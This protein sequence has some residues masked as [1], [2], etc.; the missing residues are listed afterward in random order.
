MLP[1]FTVLVDGQ[2][3]PLGDIRLLGDGGLDGRILIRADDN[4]PPIGAGG[5][6]VALAQTSFRSLT[7]VD[8]RF[9]M[10]GLPEG[11]F[12]IV[13]LFAGY[14]PVVIP[15]ISIAPNTQTTLRPIELRPDPGQPVTVSGSAFRQDRADHEGI[16]VEWVAQATAESAV[17]TTTNVEGGFTVELAAGIYTVRYRADGYGAVDVPGVAVLPLGAVG[18]VNGYLLPVDAEDRDGDGVIDAQDPDRDGDGCFDSEDKFPDDPNQCLDED[19]DGLS[20]ALDPDDDNDTLS[21]AEEIGTGVD[22]FITDPNN[23]DTDDDGFRDAEDNCPTVPNDGQEDE[24]GDG[25]GDACSDGPRITGFAPTTGAPGTTVFVRGTSFALPVRVSFGGGLATPSVVAPTEFSVTVPE[26]ARTGRITVFSAIGSST[27][28]STFVVLPGPEIIRFSPVAVRPSELVVVFGRQFGESPVVTV[29]GR[30]T[31]PESCPDGIV[32]EAERDGLD[33]ACFRPA[34]GTPSGPIGVNGALSAAALTIL[35]GPRIVRVS[36]NPVAPGQPLTFIGTGLT[37]GQGQAEPVVRFFGSTV[38]VAPTSRSDTM[39]TVTVPMDAQTGDVTIVHP[40]GDYVWRNLQIENGRPA[41]LDITPNPMRPG[42]RLRI[43]GLNLA[44]TDSVAFTGGATAA[45]TVIAA[46]EVEVTVPEGVEPGRLTLRFSGATPDYETPES[47]AVISVTEYDL[48]D[49]NLWEGLIRLADGRFV[50]V[51]QTSS[52]LIYI[53][54]DLGG[55]TRR[56]LTISRVGGMVGNATGTR[57]ALYSNREGMNQLDIVTLP[58]FGLVAT[59]ERGSGGLSPM[60]ASPDGRY[61]YST[62]PPMSQLDG[63]RSGVWVVDLQQGECRTVAQ[64]DNLFLSAIAVDGAN[65]MVT[66]PGGFGAGGVPT[67]FAKINVDPTDAIIDG[68]YT[69]D[70]GVLNTAPVSGHQIFFYLGSPLRVFVTTINGGSTTAYPLNQ[71]SASFRFNNASSSGAAVQSA[72]TRWLLRLGSSVLAGQ[73][74]D[75]KKER[76]ARKDLPRPNPLMMTALPTGTAFVYRSW[77]GPHVR[78]EI[79]E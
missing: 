28:T 30:A 65:V 13:V 62:A 8:G 16:V 61:L 34:A 3:V 55:V 36:A 51:T 1:A 33:V 12:D 25:R 24:D 49:D 75:L 50:Q 15:E 59:C 71:G 45:A 18:L 19:D 2:P 40:A 17:E 11:T 39:I 73:L 53:D 6:I 66:N 21:D 47:V 78:V 60:A 63:F 9:R 38:D 27:S 68:T 20:N 74:E 35:E 58:D 67:G 56:P 64:R 32:S 46:G 31:M 48:V 4:S 79:R 44:D 69:T 14:E 76:V 29:D 72:D 7:E 5:A 42:D 23:P 43:D 37:V 26:T 41:V 10:A 54:A 52:T 57:A 22:G 77:D 70:F